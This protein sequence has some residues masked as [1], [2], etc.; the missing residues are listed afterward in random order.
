MAKRRAEACGISEESR[1]KKM[2]IGALPES[3]QV[4]QPPSVL[5]QRK[6]KLSDAEDRDSNK[7]MRREEPEGVRHFI[8]SGA[9]ATVALTKSVYTLH[10][11][12][13]STLSRCELWRRI[14]RQYYDDDSD[15]TGAGD[16]MI[17]VC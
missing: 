11:R 10:Q 16:A 1:C 7:R 15:S 2:R 14:R 6:R 8:V 12:M 13:N 5:P 17:V 3:F 4:V 9:A